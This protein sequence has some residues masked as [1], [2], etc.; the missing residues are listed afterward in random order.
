MFHV[1][2]VQLKIIVALNYSCA[3][4][5]TMSELRT[6]LDGERG[7]GTKM[8]TDLAVTPGAVF[9]WADT[10]VPAE[11]VFK[12]SDLTGIPIQKLRPDLIGA[13]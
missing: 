4:I 8:A 5:P 12:V 10:Q 13:A 11:R 3:T 2:R 6:W 7:R 1:K 9:Q